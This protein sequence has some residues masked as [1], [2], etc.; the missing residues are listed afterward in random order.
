M[1][2]VDGSIEQNWTPGRPRCP[3]TYGKSRCN[4]TEMAVQPP[5]G[6]PGAAYGESWCNLEQNW[7]PGRPR[8]PT[9]YGKSRSNLRGKPVHPTGNPGATYGKSRCNHLREIPVQP[10]GNPGA[11]YGESRSNHGAHKIPR[12]GF[13]ILSGTHGG[14][15]FS[16]DRLASCKGARLR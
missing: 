15:L 16:V 4:L 2:P 3:T 10:T 13:G 12:E 11:T 5:T 6:N 7:T 9:T 1:V 14:P 8:C